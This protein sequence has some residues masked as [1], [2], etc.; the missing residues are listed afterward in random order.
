[1]R[2]N[3]LDG[4]RFVLFLF[5]FA[6]HY[7]EIP[8]KV[9]YFGYALPVFF[10]LS[11]FLIT[12]VL[13]TNDHPSLLK[14]LEVFYVRRILRICPAYFLAVG[15]LIA[16]GALTYPVYYLCYV[17]NLKLFAL[18]LAPGDAF[19]EWFIGAWRRESMHLWSLSVE[20][21]F[22]IVYPLALYLTP[23]RW[24]TA[25]LFLAL[26][27]SIAVR[28]WF[29]AYYPKS[30]YGTLLPVCTEYFVWGCLFA[31]WEGR[32][33]LRWLA[34]GWTLG[35]ATAAVVMLIATEFY[36]GQT[37]FLQ[38][39]TSY[40]QT[41]IALGLGFAIWGLWSIP[42]THPV[43]R[44]LSIKPLVYFG[45]MSY[46]LYLVHLIALDLFHN[47]Q[48]SVPLFGAINPLAGGFI[49]SLL[50]GMAVWHC[51]EK[52]IYELRRYLPYSKTSKSRPIPSVVT[53]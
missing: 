43:A 13:L 3:Q 27:G 34:P 36:F 21:Q 38:F 15:I 1:M 51:W 52:P 40:Y 31:W 50:M 2:K 14:R 22:Y 7:A 47:A 12:N 11:G 6:T 10:V 33:R 32:Q 23:A 26:A 44:F 35:I 39:S 4:L 8:M 24:R 9:G 29:I 16:Q 37:G 28:G 48:T 46:T 41:P 18:S 53:T 17:L 42:D 5:V 20:E 25:M 19:Y 30:F 49:A 45:G